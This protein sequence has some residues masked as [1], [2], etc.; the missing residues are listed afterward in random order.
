M[1]SI[2]IKLSIDPREA[3][4]FR[5]VLIVK[6]YMKKYNFSPYFNVTTSILASF[7]AKENRHE[8]LGVDVL[9]LANVATIDS[10]SD[11]NTPPPPSLSSSPS[12]PDENLGDPY[13]FLWRDDPH[14]SE[15]I[16]AE[17]PTNNPYFPSPSTKNQ[18][19]QN[20]STTSNRAAPP[21]S[22]V[23]DESN[24]VFVA[25]FPEEK[26]T[27]HRA[28]ESKPKLVPGNEGDLSD[29]DFINVTTLADIVKKKNSLKGK[30]SAKQ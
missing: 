8:G 24:D 17:N 5:C 19:C 15:V 20:F 29:F 3:T 26:V 13:S 4:P 27:I 10:H 23:F 30:S 16:G 11:L 28:R 7:P 9:V 1:L 25:N 6:L 18:S 21:S 2:S 22:A 12:F 14:F